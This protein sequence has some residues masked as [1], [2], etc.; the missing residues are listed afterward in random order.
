MLIEMNTL[1]SSLHFLVS[2]LAIGTAYVSPTNCWSQEKL[3]FNRDV[4]PIL[5]QACFRCHG[6]DAKT[7]EADL[8]LDTAEGAFTTRDGSAP[9]APGKL[10]QSE[11]WKRITSSD[12][13]VVMPPP[14]ANKQLTEA[15]KNA[16]KT[17]IEQ[18]A[19][20]EKHW[21]LEP[22]PTATV[23]LN[24]D[25]HLEK[26]ILKQGLSSNDRADP[27]TLV[28]RLAFTLTGL[29][30]QWEDVQF[31]VADPSPA[32]YEKLI[33]RYLLS[34]RYGE[35]MAKHWLDV[36]RYGDTH[37][38]H[39]D[40]ER[41]MWAYRDWVIRAFNKNLPFNEFTIDQLAGDLR[42]NPSQDQMVATGFNRCN[43][44]TSEGGAINEEFAFR[45]AVDRTSTT[46]QTW[47]GLT[48]GCA[49]C[50]DH[51]YD[52]LSTAEFYSLY[53]FFY[54]AAD[55]AMDGNI[56]ETQPFLPIASD[57]QKKAIAAAKV[58]E[59]DSQIELL[60]FA[61]KREN[62]TPLQTKASESKPKTIFRSQV[63]IDDE[64]PIGSKTRNTTRNAEQWLSTA[65][66]PTTSFNRARSRPDSVF[67]RQPTNRMGVVWILRSSFHKTTQNLRASGFDENS[68]KILQD[69]LAG[70]LPVFT[71]SRKDVDIQSGF[72]LQ[73]EFGFKPIIV[74][75]DE[76]YRVMDA[77]LE[78][79]P[80]I[81]YTAMINAAN[82]RELRGTEGTER[83]FNVVGQLAV[84]EIPFCL[85]GEKLLDQA[86]FATR[87]GLDRS[88]ALESITSK[89]AKALQQDKSVGSIAVGKDAD[90][91]AFNGDPLEFTSSIQWTMV[92]GRIIETNTGR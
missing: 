56:A 3:S 51:K 61:S 42:E 43:V 44:T 65:D 30:P 32:N 5:S 87:F 69:V 59:N 8:R 57:E 79:K 66:T 64:L 77:I 13:D 24:I 23:S 53:S 72:Q 89:S 54:S 28:R 82:S 62:R 81:I 2:L 68:Q 4:R 15:E 12:P 35:E 76:V 33:D 91:L 39:L 67:V 90:L 37:G 29:P 19:A 70:K 41:T 22:I 9:I 55:P 92:D 40:N 36:A 31:F 83:R 84:A 47:L 74:G 63:W 10:D 11:V 25:N 86:R 26:G 46:I 71:V 6:F 60:K 27:V 52:P 58:S 7:R 49:V 85:A 38:L 16:L 88:V 45:Y 18:G 50:H 78:R 73:D 80:T 17:W 75:G 21:A 48:G 1:K 34:P 20:Y 14:S